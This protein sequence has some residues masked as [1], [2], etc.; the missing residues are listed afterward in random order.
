MSYGHAPY[1]A[2]AFS[3]L[4]AV[5]DGSIA[6]ASNQP[7]PLSGAIAI[8]VAI[9]LGSTAPLPFAGVTDFDDP[10]VFDEGTPERLPLGGS[11]TMQAPVVLASSAAMPFGGSA[12]FSSGV[13]AVAA[14]GAGGRRARARQPQT[15]EIR[16]VIP[17][18]VLR[19][20]ELY[21]LNPVE[22]VGRFLV[23]VSPKLRR[24]QLVLAPQPSA[25]VPQFAVNG[26]IVLP[27]LVVQDAQFT[28][29]EPTLLDRLF[30][31]GLADVFLD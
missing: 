24:G 19:A 14:T 18:P 26:S 17:R 23:Q 11:I 5:S 31:M 6:F 30:A 27:R 21:V 29:A 7:L 8:V 22:V 3:E 15:L 12:S 25:L 10:I 16:L 1:S 4:P 20:G 13:P 9:V 28:A 2:A